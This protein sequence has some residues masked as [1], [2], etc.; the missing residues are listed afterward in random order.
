MIGPVLAQIQKATAFLI[1]LALGAG[2][3][4]VPAPGPIDISQPGW[5]GRQ[6]QA[7][8][9]KKANAPEI[10]GEIILATNASQRA[11][12]QFLKNPPPLLTA[13]IAPRHWQIEFIPEKRHYAGPGRPPRR[14][15][16]LQ[17]LANLQQSQ[18][19]PPLSFNKM[20]DGSFRIE[21]HKTGERIT[22][23]LNEE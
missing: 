10:A 19:K 16:W 3:R 7:L 11:F 17:L 5:R 23:F 9:G 18:A 1:L 12:V 14:L 22:L 6:G 21:D 15:L 13:E 2:C 4:S 20:D 8:L